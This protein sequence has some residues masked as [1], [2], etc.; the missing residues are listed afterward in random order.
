MSSNLGLVED[1]LEVILH[2]VGQ[3]TCSSRAICFVRQTTA[4][5]SVI[6]RSRVVKPWR[7]A[8]ADASSS[9]SRRLDE[10]GDPIGVDQ[11]PRTTTQW[12]RRVRTRAVG[13]APGSPEA[14]R[15]ALGGHRPDRDRRRRRGSGGP[16]FVDPPRGGSFAISIM[17]S[18][19][20]TMNAGS[21]ARPRRRCRAALLGARRRPACGERRHELDVG[22]VE[23]RPPSLL[24][25]R[26][27][28]PSAGR[29]GGHGAKLVGEAVGAAHLRDRGGSGRAGRRSPRC[30]WPRGPQRARGR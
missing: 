15:R 25:A 23:V 3:S 6:I 24:A 21:P 29:S 20:I 8:M 27:C 5:S 2:G 14:P 17:S 1:R 4:T 9:R 26:S 28:C 16:E 10:H 18:A 19:S 22:V 11:R 13:D 12:P 30:G 7:S